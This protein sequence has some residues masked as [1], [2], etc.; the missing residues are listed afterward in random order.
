MRT[1]LVAAAVAV[2]A[3]GVLPSSGAGAASGAT[4]EQQR[5]FDAARGKVLSAPTFKVRSVSKIPGAATS[6]TEMVVNR[7]DRYR[8]VSSSMALETIAVGSQRYT[9]RSPSDGGPW[10]QSRVTNDGLATIAFIDSWLSSFRLE[11]VEGDAFAGTTGVLG[12]RVAARARLRDGAVSELSLSGE[13]TLVTITF[14]ELGTAP[15][16]T[17][18]TRAVPSTTAP[19]PFAPIPLPRPARV[20]RSTV[21]FR[22]VREQER[23][24]SCPELTDNPPA[25]RPAVLADPDGGCIAVGAASLVLSSVDDVVA[26]RALSRDPKAVEVELTLHRS[27]AAAFDAFAAAHVGKRVAMVMFGRVLL[28]PVIQ[29]AEFNGRIVISGG[30]RTSGFT[31]AEAAEIR[32]ALVT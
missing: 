11:R 28:A 27:D 26:R 30:I 25:D 8:R 7:P 24:S 22:A 3:L 4:A 5:A 20:R 17:V 2:A 15:R 16:I 1:G 23:P 32:A 14:S 18:P 21:Q 13:G 12:D 29:G 31:L 6:V 9:R 10:T 19:D